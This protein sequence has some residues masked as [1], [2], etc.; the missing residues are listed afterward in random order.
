MTIKTSTTAVRSLLPMSTTSSTTSA[1]VSALVP[2]LRARSTTKAS[3]TG[4]WARPQ[5]STIA[6]TALGSFYPAR[7][8]KQVEGGHVATRKP[9]E[10]RG[11]RTLQRSRSTQACEADGG[12]R[13]GGQAETRWTSAQRPRNFGSIPAG[14]SRKASGK[15]FGPMPH[16]VPGKAGDV[17]RSSCHAG[18]V[19]ERAPEHRG[20]YASFSNVAACPRPVQRPMPPVVIGGESSAGRPENHGDTRRRL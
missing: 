9:N 17:Q 4:L 11:L 6:T 15:R 5:E 1:A 10:E 3:K 12:K 19:N 20:P 13:A 7:T 2:S 14:Q 18:T 8:N 16:F